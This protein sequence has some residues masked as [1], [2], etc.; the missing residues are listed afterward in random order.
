MHVG[1]GGSLYTQSLIPTRVLRDT[2]KVRKVGHGT[3]PLGLGFQ[4]GQP[5]TQLVND[6]IK[7]RTG[8][9]GEMLFAQVF[10]HV[11]D[12]IELRTI[13]WLRDQANV[14]RY[15]EIVGLMPS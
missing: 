2:S 7:R 15:L 12:R 10:P 8:K 6:L 5:F 13:R 11:F 9:I 3:Q 4:L 14:L 1:G